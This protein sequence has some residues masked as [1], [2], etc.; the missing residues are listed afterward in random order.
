MTP[1]C[2]NSGKSNASHDSKGGNWNISAFRNKKKKPPKQELSAD[3][4]G[5]WTFPQNWRKHL[6]D[7]QYQLK[8]TDPFCVALLSLA[9]AQLWTFPRKKKTFLC[10]SLGT[11]QISFSHPG[12]EAGC[13]SEI[14][15]VY[16]KDKCRHRIPLTEAVPLVLAVVKCCFQFEFTSLCFLPSSV[17]FQNILF[18]SKFKPFAI[19]DY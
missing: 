18:C 12:T 4:C 6:E 14:L 19:Q 5:R 2:H 7:R 9:S 17:L 15:A 1:F 13:N 3:K 8:S 11:L 10:K 16:K